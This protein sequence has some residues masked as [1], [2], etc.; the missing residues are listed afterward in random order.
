MT[1]TGMSKNLRTA[2]QR[3]ASTTEAQRMGE[4]LAE[5]LELEKPQ[6]EDSVEFELAP[7]AQVDWSEGVE[8]LQ[9]K[10]AN[11]LYK[12]LGL[13]RPS[14]PFFREKIAVEQETSDDLETSITTTEGFSLR[15]HQLV[16]VTKM[17][18][19][20]MTSQ[21]VLL[22]D[23]VGLG[24]TVQVLA[25]FAMLAYYR[26]FYAQHEKY[27]GMW[28]KR[29]ACSGNGE[30]TLAK[31]KQGEWKNYNGEE[32]VLPNDPFLM[33]VPP[34]L[35]DQVSVECNRFLEPGSI[36][37]I[38]ITGAVTQHGEVWQ[39][40]GTISKLRPEMKLYI[41]STTVSVNS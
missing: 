30:L 22:M 31:G 20:A 35:V 2:L 25:F 37:V 16:G 1:G 18:E 29:C 4:Q 38:T 13:E 39:A 33:V 7:E 36:D 6:M 10:S 19:R 23:D 24:K 41:A 14:I 3:L 32:N 26:E 34:T 28:G 40:A 12:M 8:H 11:D 17:V 21:P 27:P 15:W 9:D 5:R